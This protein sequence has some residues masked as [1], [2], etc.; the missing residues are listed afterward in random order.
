MS[1]LLLL[2]WAPG[3]TYSQWLQCDW[4]GLCTV[5]LV[6]VMYS[7]TGVGMYNVTWLITGVQY[8]HTHTHTHTH[9]RTHS[10]CFS[11]PSHRC[12][13]QAWLGQTECW[14]EG[15]CHNQVLYLWGPIS[16]YIIMF[17]SVYYKYL[18]LAYLA[19]IPSA[20]TCTYQGLVVGEGVV[21]QCNSNSSLYSVFAATI[22]AC[23]IWW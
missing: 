9:T 16:L 6:W 21:L 20:A 11:L 2:S 17:I 7:V 22:P 23:I 14:R 18:Y 10:E 3:T 1:F 4:C 5:W 15:V 8:A 12:C 13:L 19:G